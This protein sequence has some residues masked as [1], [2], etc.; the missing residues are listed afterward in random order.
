MI[1]ATPTYHRMMDEI[2]R[3]S[4]QEQLDLLEGITALLRS[5]LPPQ[6]KHNLLELE[7]LGAQIWRGVRA[8][9]Y[10]AQERIAWDG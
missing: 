3:L 1:A 2:R 7:G 9:D 4:A 8:Q 10:V 6:P 5:A